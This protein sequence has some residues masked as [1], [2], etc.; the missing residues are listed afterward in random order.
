MKVIQRIF[1]TLLV[2]YTLQSCQY[3]DICTA[4]VPSTPKLRIEFHDQERPGLLKAAENFNVRALGDTAYYFSA[5]INDTT[6]AIPLRTDK[7]ETAYELI[8]HQGDSLQTKRDT[9]IFTYNTDE[10]FISRACG[11][12]SIF[13]DFE[14]NYNPTSKG[15]I[16]NIQIADTTKR[17]TDDKKAALF[18]YF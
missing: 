1:C 7:K 18:I 2:L 10:V 9:L 13:T 4:E 6:V 11:F 5:P 8:F 16:K 3:N 15:W 12:K 14:V 17:I